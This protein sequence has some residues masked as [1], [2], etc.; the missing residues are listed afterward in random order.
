MAASMAP[1]STRLRST[2]SGSSSPPCAGGEVEAR[3]RSSA[4]VG[5][6]EERQIA[7]GELVEHHLSAAALAAE[8]RHPRPLP[9]GKVLL[10]DQQL[11][12]VGVAALAQVGRDERQHARRAAKVVD[13][14][15]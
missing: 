2:S 10:D 11:V 3:E 7:F 12:L 6:R 8:A 5:L 14:V 4:N 1:S 13:G 9:V 15:E